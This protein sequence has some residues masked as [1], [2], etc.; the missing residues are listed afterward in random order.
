MS[1]YIFFL[2]KRNQENCVQLNCDRH[3]TTLNAQQA[4]Y[5]S[6]T[7]SN[8][9]HFNFIIKLIIRNEYSCGICVRRFFYSSQLFNTYAIVSW[10]KRPFYFKL[11]IYTEARSCTTA[12]RGHGTCSMAIVVLF[13]SYFIFFFFSFCVHLYCRCR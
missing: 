8:S 5:H 3:K 6:S 2:F 9:L 4:N 10:L 1:I 13:F 7:P 12:H 11:Y